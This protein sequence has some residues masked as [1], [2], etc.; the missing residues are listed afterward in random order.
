MKLLLTLLLVLLATPVW[1]ADFDRPL[2]AGAIH[3][4]ALSAPHDDSTYDTASISLRRVDNG[5]PV[6][7]MAATPGETIEGDTGLITNFGANV[8]LEAVAHSEADCAGVESVPSTDRYRV[9]WGAPGAPTLVVVA[10][11]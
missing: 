3:V 7:C 5:D 1:A 11:P 10:T 8:M 9:V 2:I 6:F 4:K